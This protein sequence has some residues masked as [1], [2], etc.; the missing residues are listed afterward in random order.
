MANTGY[1]ISHFSLTPSFKLP[2]LKWLGSTILFFTL[3]VSATTRAEETEPT[4]DQIRKAYLSE[5]MNRAAQKKLSGQRYWRL[6]LHYQ[7]NIFGGYTSL[8][9]GPGF[10]MSP[11]G[12]TDPQAELE[13]TLAKCFS[14][15]LVGTSQQQPQ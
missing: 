13:A 11:N 5:L 4:T 1:R 8:A 7:K 14:D 6:L 10:F 2:M 15:E 12:R 9:D 3:L